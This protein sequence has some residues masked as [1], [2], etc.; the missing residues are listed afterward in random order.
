MWCSLVIQTLT[1]HVLVYPD[2]SWN[3]LLPILQ[4][5]HLVL[6]ISDYRNLSSNSY[7]WQMMSLK[8]YLKMGVNLFAK[9][10]LLMKCDVFPLN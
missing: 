3:E 2:W 10:I 4:V 6:S 1:I 8:T 9:V 7:K 5:A